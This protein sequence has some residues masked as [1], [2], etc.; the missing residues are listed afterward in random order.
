MAA[1]TDAPPG[2]RTHLPG[3]PGVWVFILGDMLM[4]A[5]FFVVFVYYRRQDVPLFVHS[6]STLNQHFGAINTLLMLTSSWFVALAIHSARAHVAK[7]CSRFFVLAF[8]CGLGFV[9]IKFFEYREKIHAGIMLTTNDFYMYYYMF[10]GLH[11]MHVLI[12]MG[13]LTYLTS[14]ARGGDF[15]AK[16]LNVLESG[17]SFWHMVDILWIVLFALLYL[18]K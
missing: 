1:S 17:A 14:I 16:N 4:F 9:V 12:G 7:L 6:Q 8:L 10:T 18:M 15:Q 11:L 5:A 2:A 3:E 13:V